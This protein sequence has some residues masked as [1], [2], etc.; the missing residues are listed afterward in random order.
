[1]IDLQLPPESVR[2]PDDEKTPVSTYRSEFNIRV[3]DTDPPEP[4]ATR[5]SHLPIW[6]RV[7]SVTRLLEPS[8]VVEPGDRA[9]DGV[10]S[11]SET[12]YMVRR[13]NAR[14]LELTLIAGLSALLAATVALWLARAVSGRDS[15]A[16]DPTHSK[17]RAT[18][19]VSVPLIPAY[20]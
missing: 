2:E 13:R 10:D 8:I 6:P 5:E 4:V 20:D 15:G 18:P 16:A 19:A 11:Q 17:L 7:S 14:T 1:M 9:D 3:R 12:L